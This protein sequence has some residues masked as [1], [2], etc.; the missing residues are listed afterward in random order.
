MP[1]AAP[2]SDSF[3]LGE[4]RWRCGNTRSDNSGVVF[5]EF[6]PIPQYSPN[7]KWRHSGEEC[8]HPLPRNANIRT[9]DGFYS[10]IRNSAER[11]FITLPKFTFPEYLNFHQRTQRANLWT[12]A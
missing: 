5:Q 6:A 12:L 7:A 9:Q 11:A 1:Q 2:H 3:I 10:T 8:I 4:K